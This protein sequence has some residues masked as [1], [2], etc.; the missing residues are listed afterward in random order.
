VLTDGTVLVMSGDMQLRRMSIKDGFALQMAV[1][2][3]YH[4]FIISG[5]SSEGVKERLVKLGVNNVFMSVN[6]KKQFLSQ[7]LKQHHLL[8]EDVL[9]MGDDLPDLDLMHAV[10]LST[11]PADA[12]PE[13]R[14]VVKYV[15]PVNGGFG[16][17]RDVI[18]KV[19]KQNDHWQYETS[20]ASR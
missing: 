2:K 18:E 9:Y 16:C 4:M 19:L 3:G 14:D 8:W 5:G 6:N 7:L 20:V 17:A 10:G 13:I 15:S 12:A 11:C 1:L